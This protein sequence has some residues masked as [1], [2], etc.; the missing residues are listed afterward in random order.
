MNVISVEDLQDLSEYL[1]RLFKAN[2]DSVPS[3]SSGVAEAAMGI[4]NL[5]EGCRYDVNNSG[6]DG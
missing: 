4:D 6:G 1:W 5:I 3:F 2:S